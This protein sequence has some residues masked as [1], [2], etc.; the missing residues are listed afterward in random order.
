MPG[1]FIIEL[2]EKDPVEGRKENKEMDLPG[3]SGG[4]SSVY[5]KRSPRGRGCFAGKKNNRVAHVFSGR[6]DLQEIPLA[7][8]VP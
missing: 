7:V 5:W 1:H 4:N 3:E 2:L 8:I 6:L